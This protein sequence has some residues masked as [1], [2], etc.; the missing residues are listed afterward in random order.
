MNAFRGALITCSYCDRP[1]A[2]SPVKPFQAPSLRFKTAYF[3]S[4]KFSTGTKRQCLILNYYAFKTD[5]IH[6]SIVTQSKLLLSLVLHSAGL[7]FHLKAHSTLI[8]LSSTA[9]SS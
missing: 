9:L 2:V 4:V 5:I 6:Q 7:Q 1:R 3:N 8:H